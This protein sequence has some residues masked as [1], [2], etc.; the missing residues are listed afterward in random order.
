MRNRL[1]LLVLSAIVASTGIVAQTPLT[2]PSF[3]GENAA[4]VASGQNL[5]QAWDGVAGTNVKW[6]VEIAGLAHSSPIVY[7]DRLFVTTAISS[8]P[9]ATFKPGLY[10][11]GTASEDHSVHKWVVMAIDRRNGHTMWERI[12]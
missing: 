10:G 5:P 3:R 11:E 2:W 6:K 7:G 12:A 4:G 1:G 9:D 8:L